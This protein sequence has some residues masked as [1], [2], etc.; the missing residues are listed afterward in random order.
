MLYAVLLKDNTISNQNPKQM[1]FMKSCL[2]ND[3]EIDFM[4]YDINSVS[5][6]VV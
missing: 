1:A 3:A 6:S 4:A 5:N 2:V